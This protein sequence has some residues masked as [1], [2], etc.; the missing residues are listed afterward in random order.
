MEAQIHEGKPK[1]TKHEERSKPNKLG[2]FWT[3]GL[4]KSVHFQGPYLRIPPLD[5]AVIVIHTAL[6]CQVFPI[7]I[8][9]QSNRS[10]IHNCVLSVYSSVLPTF[11]F[12]L[13]LL[14]SMLHSPPYFQ[15]S[16]HTIFVAFFPHYQCLI[17]FT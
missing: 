5:R 2:D 8:S 7:K 3:F 11:Q 16:H 1:S 10:N 9:E 15:P 13:L 14:F 17:S 12:F 4:C 6:V